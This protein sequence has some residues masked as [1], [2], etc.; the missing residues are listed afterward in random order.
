VFKEWRALLKGS[1]R[2]TGENA[3]TLTQKKNLGERERK[4][5]WFSKASGCGGKLARDAIREANPRQCGGVQVTGL[6]VKNGKG[7]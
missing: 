1:K 6:N 5:E 4:I 3:F 2:G 7:V